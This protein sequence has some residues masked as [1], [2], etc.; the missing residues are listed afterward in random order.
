MEIFWHKLSRFSCE[1]TE[2]TD[3]KRDCTLK[4]TSINF[5]Y[6]SRVPLP[7][8]TPETKTWIFK[9]KTNSQKPSSASGEG[10]LSFHS[11]QIRSIDLETPQV[12]KFEIRYP[13]QDL[14]S[15]NLSNRFWPLGKLVNVQ[16]SDSI[17][18]A[19]F[20]SLGFTLCFIWICLAAYHFYF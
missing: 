13:S 12:L 1:L 8:P 4:I 2:F 19:S 16:E 5:N 6:D 11:N 3:G 17:L 20:S 18:A 10:L 15:S 14:E 7:T 9:T